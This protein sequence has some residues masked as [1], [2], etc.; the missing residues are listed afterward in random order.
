MTQF[1]TF[2][3]SL[4]EWDGKDRIAEFSK[5]IEMQLVVYSGGGRGTSCISKLIIEVCKKKYR[6]TVLRKTRH[7]QKHSNKMAVPIRAKR[8]NFS[9]P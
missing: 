9:V 2:M 7:R 5:C 8:N 6:Y 1:E 3:N 4:P